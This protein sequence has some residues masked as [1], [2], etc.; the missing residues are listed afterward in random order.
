MLLDGS[1]WR[2]A[3]EN[4][5]SIVRF[6]NEFTETTIQ[7]G[8]ATS[9]ICP[10]L[11]GTTMVDQKCTALK[12]SLNKNRHIHQRTRYQY[13]FRCL[14]YRMGYYV[15]RSRNT[16]VLARGRKRHFDQ[17]E[18]TE[19]SLICSPATRTRIPKLVDTRVHRQHAKES[20]GTVSMLLQR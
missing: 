19:D 13:P 15:K 8:E 14:R 20:W 12:R 5:A 9:I 16:R 11:G 17:C 4:P 6:S 3:A 10:S 7:L 2:S 18:R 1:H